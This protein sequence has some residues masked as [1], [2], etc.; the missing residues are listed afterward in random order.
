[1][2]HGVAAGGQLPTDGLVIEVGR[3]LSPG[4]ERGATVA[5]VVI[6]ALTGQTLLTTPNADAALIP[7]SNMKLVTSAA[8]LDLYGPDAELTTKLS[9]SGDDLVVVGGGDPALGDPDIEAQAGRTPM[10]VFDDWAQALRRRGVRRIAGDIVVIDAVF[11]GA[12]AHP[13]WSRA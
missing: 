11:D 8:A 13:T 3:A 4:A 1:M 7:A 2:F 12:L 10:S 5:V 6:D 9:I